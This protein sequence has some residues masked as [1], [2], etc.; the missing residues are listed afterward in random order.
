MSFSGML[1]RVAPVRTDVLEELSASIIRVTRMGEL[2]TTYA[3]IKHPRK[4]HS[5]E[6]ACCFVRARKLACH[7]EGEIWLQGVQEYGAREYNWP[8]A[9]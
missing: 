3:V 6:V 5:S 9:G 7:S 2:G 1:H 8:K 4:R